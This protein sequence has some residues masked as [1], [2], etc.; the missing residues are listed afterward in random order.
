MLSIQLDPTAANSALIVAVVTAF[1]GPLATLWITY[2]FQNRQKE[3][4]HNNSL[5]AVWF[6][7]KLNAAEVITAQYSLLLGSI[8]HIN[9]SIKELKRDEST[10]VG[11]R[12]FDVG[13]YL[14]DQ[15]KQGLE[16]ASKLDAVLA[17]TL[18]LYF[19]VPEA[20]S[21]NLQNLAVSFYEM[22]PEISNNFN[23]AMETPSESLE[24]LRFN[25]SIDSFGAKYA[26][27]KSTIESQIRRIRDSF[28]GYDFD[29]IA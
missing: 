28:L 12:V 20:Q 1:A 8:F 29:N 26:L 16:K 2:Y 5:R 23:S 17:N 14:L 15:S 22:I 3:K 19:N 21:L 10:M 6:T 9:L 4:E 24:W 18:F 7:K 13:D 27:L 25:D 11:E